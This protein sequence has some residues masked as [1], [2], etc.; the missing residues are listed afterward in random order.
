MRPWERAKA[1]KVARVCE[2]IGSVRPFYHLFIFG[3]LL[4]IA[5]L[6]QI[7]LYMLFKVRVNFNFYHLA[8]IPAP[9]ENLN[10]I[11]L[12]GADENHAALHVGEFKKADESRTRR[13]LSDRDVADCMDQ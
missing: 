12:D 11:P 5:L 10:R 6:L 8:A 9:R 1:S 13:S 3:S 7:A 2:K 4:V